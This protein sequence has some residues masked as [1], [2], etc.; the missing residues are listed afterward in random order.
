MKEYNQSKRQYK[1]ASKKIEY[2]CSWA[3]SMW[4]VELEQGISSKV[5][6][7][8]SDWVQDDDDVKKDESSI[9]RLIRG[10]HSKDGDGNELSSSLGGILDLGIGNSSAGRSSSSLLVDEQMVSVS[11]VRK[12]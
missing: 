6:D 7:Y 2:F 5:L 1:L 4:S 11:T 12:K 8:I 10:M 3:S 9:E